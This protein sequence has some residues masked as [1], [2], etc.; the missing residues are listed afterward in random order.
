MCCARR[1]SSRKSPGSLGP[2]ETA[3]KPPSQDSN[4]GAKAFETE[5]RL[6]VSYMT[7]ACEKS[8]YSVKQECK[9]EAQAQKPRRSPKLWNWPTPPFQRPLNKQANR[10]PEAGHRA[11]DLAY[12]I[13]RFVVIIFEV[14]DTVHLY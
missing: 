4:I 11:I 6:G 7:V 2:L 13:H 3:W 14:H 9:P 12:Y 5:T 1:P 10:G 8:G